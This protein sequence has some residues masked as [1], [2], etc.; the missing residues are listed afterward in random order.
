MFVFFYIS[1]KKRGIMTK[2]I[3]IVLYIAFV[4]IAISMSGCIEETTSASSENSTQQSNTVRPT[5]NPTTSTKT[6]TLVNESSIIEAG[7]IWY[8]PLTL[9][10]TVSINVN[11][12]VTNG[13]GVLIYL[14]SDNAQL[15]NLLNGNYFYYNSTLSADYK[16]TSFNKS[17]QLLSG[18]Y[19]IAIENPNLLFSQTVSRTVTAY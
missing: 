11:V 13:D 1:K 17:A 9:T 6:I 3:N 5:T 14:L 4:L 10:N 16:V 12:N 7:H 18:T 8:T 15:V 2:Q 19:F